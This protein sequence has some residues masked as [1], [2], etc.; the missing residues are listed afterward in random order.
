MDTFK[1][2]TKAPIFWIISVVVVLVLGGVGIGLYQ[3]QKVSSQ[4]AKVQSNPAQAGQLTDDRQRELI[5]EVSSKIMLP[6]EEKPTVAIVS[7]I[8][9][10]KDQQFFANGQNGDVVLI[11]MN[12]KKAI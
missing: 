2:L 8:N 12:S 10:L 7:D 11:Y 9:R 5:A 1:H 6:A 4:L 3:Y